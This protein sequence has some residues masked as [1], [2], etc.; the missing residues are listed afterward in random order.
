MNKIAINSI[1]FTLAR[2]SKASTSFLI[3]PFM[4]RYMGKED[5]GLFFIISSCI[6]IMIPISSLSPCKFYHPPISFLLSL[7][8]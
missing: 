4:L 5:I 1:F 2:L 6:A 8:F 3:L 7:L